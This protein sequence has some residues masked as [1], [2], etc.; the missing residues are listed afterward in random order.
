MESKMSQTKQRI[1]YMKR[2]E[3]LERPINLKQKGNAKT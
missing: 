1:L 3:V 2:N